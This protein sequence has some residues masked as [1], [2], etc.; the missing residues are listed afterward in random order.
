MPE[1]NPAPKGSDLNQK[2]IRQPNV[3]FAAVEFVADYGEDE[4]ISQNRLMSELVTSGI[5]TRLQRPDVAA[6]MERA[7]YN[8]AQSVR[9][10]AAR[11][12]HTLDDLKELVDWLR[13]NGCD[14][15]ADAFVRGVTMVEPMAAT[16]ISERNEPLA[17]PPTPPPSPGAPPRGPQSSPRGR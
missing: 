14:A 16:N 5:T 4:A 10:N 15:A 17:T 12:P 7:G 2:L 9:L 11:W 1:E 13:A 8:A 6:N 3:V